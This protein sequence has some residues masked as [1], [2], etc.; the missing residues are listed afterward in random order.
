MNIQESIPVDQSA[1][2][3][4]QPKVFQHLEHFVDTEAEHALR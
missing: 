1:A 4:R 2:E 3:V